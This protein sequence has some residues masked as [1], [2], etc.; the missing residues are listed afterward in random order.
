MN[1]LQTQLDTLNSEFKVLSGKISESEARQQ[2]LIIQ[3]SAHGL[4][5]EAQELQVF[6]NYLSPADTE[7]CFDNE[8]SLIN[9]KREYPRA[10]WL[11]NPDNV[12]FFPAIQHQPES[13]RL[14]TILVSRLDGLTRDGVIRM[15]DTTL[16]VETAGLNGKLYLDARGRH[17]TDG[18]ATF[19]ADI[20][21]TADWMKDNSTMEVVLEDT[22]TLMQAKDCPN[23]ALYCGWYSLR[24]YQDSCQWLPGAVGYHVASYEMF[25][26]H[27]PNEKGWVV[28][29]L[30]H[31]FCGTLKRH[32]GALSQRFSKT[33]QVFSS[34]IIG[35]L[36]PGGSLGSDKPSCQL[37]HRLRG[38]P[39][40]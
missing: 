17:G 7:A 4:L 36:H 35:A 13:Q 10:K 33:F 25:S 20:R 40:L 37:A 6:L 30:T 32:G 9:E 19:D 14:K 26:L 23:A 15:I 22:E 3:R 8:L 2:L 28:N 27:D 24:T 11:A 34:V 29:L 5:G 38:R 21:E 1:A 12:E 18:Y 39:S 31:G 16:K